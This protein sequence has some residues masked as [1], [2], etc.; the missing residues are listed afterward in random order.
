MIHRDGSV[1]ARF[2]HDEA[3]AGQNL[4]NSRLMQRVLS[5]G[6]TVDGIFARLIDGEER[7]GAAS[8]LSDVPT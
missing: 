5:E 2:P 6:G 4:L 1:L 3:W 8:V 7:I